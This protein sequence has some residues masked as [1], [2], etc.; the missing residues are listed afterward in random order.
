MSKLHSYWQSQ[1]SLIW[2]KEGKVPSYLSPQLLV[3]SPYQY[4]DYK[5]K[6]THDEAVMYHNFDL[7]LLVHTQ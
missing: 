1:L 5:D 7:R 3:F 6:P 4:D 2:K